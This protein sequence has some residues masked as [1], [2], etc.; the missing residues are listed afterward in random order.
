MALTEAEVTA[1][2]A[3]AKK[4]LEYS[5]QAFALV[6]DVASDEISSSLVIPVASDHA[7]YEA[8]D[9]LKRQA[10]ALEALA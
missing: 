9:C 7:N 6:L 1:A 10:A 4:Y 5:T 3:D 8:Y 2:K